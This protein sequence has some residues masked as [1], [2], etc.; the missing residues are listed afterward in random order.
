[1]KR[2]HHALAGHGDAG[3]A[4]ALVAAGLRDEEDFCPA[5]AAGEVPFKLR[6][7]D[8]AGVG[9]VVIGVEIS[10]RIEYVFSPVVREGRNEEFDFMHFPEIIHYF[11]IL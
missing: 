4:A 11:S 6:L 1:M 9:D 5:Q 7:A 10:P 8:G 2:E 3:E